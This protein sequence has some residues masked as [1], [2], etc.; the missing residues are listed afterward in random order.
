MYKLYIENW[1]WKKEK[2]DLNVDRKNCA[3]LQ[4]MDETK[5]FLLLIIKKKYYK[6]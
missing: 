6:T 4:A 1:F 3:L 2:C 5:S